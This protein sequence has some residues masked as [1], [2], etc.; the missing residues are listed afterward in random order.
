MRALGGGMCWFCGTCWVT[1]PRHGVLCVVLSLGALS[2][3][4]VFYVLFCH[5]LCGFEILSALL[6]HCVIMVD[7][8]MEGVYLTPHTSCIVCC[9]SI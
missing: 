6:L 8:G 9:T 4:M 1:F 2:V 5:L 3:D 7:Y